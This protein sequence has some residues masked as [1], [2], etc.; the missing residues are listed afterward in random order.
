MEFIFDERTI[1]YFS[2]NNLIKHVRPKY[3][4]SDLWNGVILM[5]H[6]DDE[7]QVNL[8]LPSTNAPVLK[9]FKL[10]NIQ[11]N[12][13]QDI[14]RFKNFIKKNNRYKCVSLVKYETIT[15]YSN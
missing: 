5:S 14:L 8:N 3:E 9:I 1:I 2:K 13:I 7:E 10:C 4:Y 11:W 15:P 12:E 6:W